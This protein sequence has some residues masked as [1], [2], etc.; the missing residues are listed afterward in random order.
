MNNETELHACLN[1][2]KDEKEIPLVQLSYSGN[3][4]WICPQC[5]PVLIH[6]TDQLAEKLT[7]LKRK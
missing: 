7:D 5:L 1:C 3:Q 2:G 4:A 6:H